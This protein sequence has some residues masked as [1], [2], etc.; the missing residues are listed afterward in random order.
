[1]RL[2]AHRELGWILLDRARSSRKKDGSASEEILSEDRYREAQEQFSSG[3][4]ID[5]DD[6]QCNLGKGMCLHFRN[7][8]REAIFYLERS[9]ALSE[10]KGNREHRGHF[11]LGRAIEETQL[12]QAKA[13]D[14]FRKSVEQD[15][16]QA[17]TPLYAHLVS[18]LPVYVRFEDPQ[19]QWFLDR[20]LAFAGEDASYWAHV[21]TFASG[22][23]S[24]TSPD[25]QHVGWYAR[26]LARARSGKIEKAVEDA[27]RL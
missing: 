8:N 5:P 4:E 24:D 6:E 3:L 12:L 10:A 14:Q 7:L 26:A 19:F 1:Y 17:F 13:A 27:Q 2:E 20:M 25:R 16:E 9:V 18:V 23:A 22:L 21:E 11:Y 15:T